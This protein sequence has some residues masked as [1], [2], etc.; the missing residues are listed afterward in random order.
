MTTVTKMRLSKETLS[1]LKNFASINSNILIKP[2]NIL[3]TMSQGGNILAEAKI[4]EE[5]DTTVPIWDLNQFLGVVSM[6][7]NPDL[8]FGDKY[9]DISNGRSS[10]RYFYSSASLLTVPTKEIKMPSP[11][12]SFNLDE[13]DLNEML[14]ASS[15]LHV[16]N[17]KIVGENGSLIMVVDDPKNTTSNSFSVL[18]DE[19]YTGPDYS[20]YVNISEI[21]FYPGSYKVDLTK[22]IITKFNHESGNLCY[23]I[24]I[25][26]G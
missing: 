24:A 25:N 4:E 23:Y 26:K 13:N 20:G 1:I 21:K 19:N 11:I 12:S 6:F 9:V 14:K 5:F 8:E 2:G 10:V 17:L 18:I 15:I 7:A 22:T 16:S 3:R